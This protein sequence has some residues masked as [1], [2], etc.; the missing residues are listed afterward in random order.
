MRL[1]P[2]QLLMTALLMASLTGC[3]QM[4]PLYMPAP[5]TGGGAATA[6]PD[7]GEPGATDEVNTDP[8][9]EGA[10]GGVPTAFGEEVPEERP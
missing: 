7:S 8:E 5:E 9:A 2:A 6:V 4:G 10:D 1:A 3:G